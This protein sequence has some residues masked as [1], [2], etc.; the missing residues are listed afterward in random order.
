MI[1]MKVIQDRRAR[2][3]CGVEVPAQ[4]YRSERRAQIRERT[5]EAQEVRLFRHVFQPE[6]IL[7]DVL[8]QGCELDSCQLT[9]STYNI[10]PQPLGYVLLRGHWTW[11]RL[12]DLTRR[13]LG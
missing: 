9:C 11:R 7:D 12:E 1:E 10:V 3:P 4:V 8:S 2:G 5:R 13:G 6:S